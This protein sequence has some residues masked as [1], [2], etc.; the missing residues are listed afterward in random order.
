MNTLSYELATLWQVTASD[1]TQLAS[2]VGNFRSVRM[3]YDESGRFTGRCSVRFDSLDSAM[4]AAAKYNGR[5][6]DKRPMQ[7]TLVPTSSNH[8]LL[9]GRSTIFDR[10]GKRPEERLGPRY[11]DTMNQNQRDQS[12]KTAKDNRQSNFRGRNKNYTSMDLDAEIEE[13]M[14]CDLTG[15]G[16][17]G[18]ASQYATRKNSRL[19]K[20][21]ANNPSNHR[22]I[23]NYEEGS[24]PVPVLM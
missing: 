2:A 16:Q 3:D 15:G 23:I 14:S 9:E 5:E 10:L 18:S 11:E 17:G 22:R 20:T 8:N 24:V 12:A 6:L 13:Y 21:Q 7:W 19:E 1:I 4:L